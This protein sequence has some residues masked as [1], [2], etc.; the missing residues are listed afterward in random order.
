[1]PTPELPNL[2]DLTDKMVDLVCRMEYHM[3]AAD[4]LKTPEFKWRPAYQKSLVFHKRKKEHAIR[5]FE[6]YFPNVDPD[7]I[8]NE[9]S[10]NFD[11]WVK[12]NL[13]LGSEPA[14]VLE[15]KDLL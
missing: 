12:D 4:V 6:K 13:K 1:M 11:G 10:E 14:G 9:Y 3:Q 7:V 2:P 5:D 8:Y 15:V